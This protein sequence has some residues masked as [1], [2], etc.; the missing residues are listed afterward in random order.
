[1]NEMVGL[2][3][4]VRFILNLPFI[5]APVLEPFSPDSPRYIVATQPL[6]ASMLKVIYES[7]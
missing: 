2:V 6:T 3:F 1:M 7:M 5:F 4:S